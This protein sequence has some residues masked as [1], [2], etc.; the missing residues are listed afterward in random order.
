MFVRYPQTGKVIEGLHG[1]SEFGLVYV[2]GSRCPRIGV[3]RASAAVCCRWQKKRAGGRGC[4]RIAL[5]TPS[6]EVPSSARTGDNVAATIDCEPLGLTRYY[7]TKKLRGASPV[8]GV[9]EA[10]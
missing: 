3:A 8:T 5:T 4:T 7:M 6:I 10:F 2:L 1:R 9:R